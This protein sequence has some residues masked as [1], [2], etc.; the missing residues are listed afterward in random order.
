MVVFKNAESKFLHVAT[1]EC[2]IIAHY[3]LFLTDWSYS[4]HF[5]LLIV[6][7]PITFEMGTIGSC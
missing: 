1:K 4:F 3:E 2:V 5:Q 6:F 7:M